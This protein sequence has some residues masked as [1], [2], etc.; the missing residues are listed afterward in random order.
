VKSASPAV[1]AWLLSRKPSVYADLFNF[2]FYDGTTLNITSYPA[3]LSFAGITYYGT[4]KPS[5]TRTGWQIKNTPEIPELDITLLSTGTDFGSINIKQAIIAGKLDGSLLY[6]QRMIIDPVSKAQIGVLPLFLG[7]AGAVTANPTGAKITYRG[8]NVKMDQNYPRN[9][10]M[11]V[12]IWGLYNSGCTLNSATYTFPGTVAENSTA[13]L[14]NWAADPSGGHYTRTIL[15]TTA[16][17]AQLIYPLD[18]IPAP[19]DTFQIT[20]GCTKGLHYCSTAFGNQQHWRGFPYVP[21][22]ETAF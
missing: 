7:I 21:P 12:C 3:N 6:F 10:Y 17:G 5:I 4:R 9:V 1:I 2:T 11:Q 18:A 20:Y 14:V 8:R 15:T 16:G 13:N 22:A 19:G